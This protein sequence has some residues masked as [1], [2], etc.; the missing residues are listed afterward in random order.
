[1]KRRPT[2]IILWLSLGSPFGTPGEL[3][4]LTFAWA[5]GKNLC[6]KLHFKMEQLCV[7]D[8]MHRCTVLVFETT[9][10]SDLK[11]GL[12]LLVLKPKGRKSE[13]KDGKQQASQKSFLPPPRSVFLCVIDYQKDK[14][15]GISAEM[16]DRAS[17]KHKT[18][19]VL[20]SHDKS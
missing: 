14:R 19:R 11:E 8:G 13:V 5:E 4:A 6:L 3:G 17:E 2:L 15:P 16:R 7:D 10:E 9:P 18:L 12:C 1:M 20:I